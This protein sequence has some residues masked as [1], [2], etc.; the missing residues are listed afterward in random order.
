MPVRY[1]FNPKSRTID[2]SCS[3]KL[4]IDEIMEYFDNMKK[5]PS[6]L[7][8]AVE[9]VDLS[10]VS[11]FAVDPEGALTM[12]NGF[13]PAQTSKSILATIL[14]GMTPLNEGLAQLIKAR[15]SQML[16][17]HPFVLAGNEGEARAAAAKILGD[18]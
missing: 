6:V 4:S 12:P 17:G 8:G 3:G 5:D 1:Q 18:S 14:F 16:P 13:V 9:L 2:I 10:Q 15:F 7:K 11:Y